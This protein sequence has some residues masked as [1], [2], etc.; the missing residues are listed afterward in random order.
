MRPPIEESQVL[1]GM[2][3]FLLKVT[4]FWNAINTYLTKGRRGIPFNAFTAYAFIYAFPYI[5]FQLVS[6]LVIPLNVETLSIKELSEIFTLL[7]Q[8][9]LSCIPSHKM[10]KVKEIQRYWAKFSNIASLVAISCATLCI[11]SWIAVPG[12]K[13]VDDTGAVSKKILGG[14]DWYLVDREY[15]RTAQMMMVRTCKPLTLKVIKMYPVSVEILV[16]GRDAGWD[17]RRS[18]SQRC[19]LRSKPT[20]SDPFMPYFMALSL[21]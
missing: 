1:E 19:R 18:V 12:I 13:A 21:L 5:L 2:S 7:R 11:T 15:A 17:A 9:F 10:T 20:V 14:C 4:G 16:G 3:V 6:V 8:D